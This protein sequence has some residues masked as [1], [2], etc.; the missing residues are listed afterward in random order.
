MRKI[1][2]KFV[3]F[4]DNINDKDSIFFKLI[5][6]RYDIEI[7]DSPEY[8]VYSVFGYEHLKYDC[9]RIFYT[10]EQVS[11]DFDIADY[12]I[13]F[14]TLFFNDRYL[15]FPL[16]A[17]KYSP[18]M[19]ALIETDYENINF[20][21]FNKRDFA[22]FTYSNSKATSPRDQFFDKLNSLRKVSSPGRHLNNT[23]FY[24]DNKSEFESGFKFSIAFENSSYE[25]YS[26]EKILDSFN[27]KTIP[28]YYGDETIETHFHPESFINLHNF[29]NFDEAIGYILKIEKDHESLQKM[30]KHKKFKD[31]VYLYQGQLLDFFDNIFSQDIVK[32]RRRPYSNRSR[33]KLKRLQ[34]IRL[35]TS[36]K[37]SKIF[38]FILRKAKK[39]IYLK[40]QIIQKI[41]RN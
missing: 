36:Y 2:I 24:V 19:L 40:K 13:G 9:I 15:R 27:A 1:K 41:R 39:I 4:W 33:E 14:D 11:P 8:I 20:E 25:G 10:G 28:I 37:R 31:N 16:Y 29:I 34:F 18:E 17:L 26:T 22:V 12:A 21:D 3:D 32:A 23:G 38:I 30:L 5:S 7:S 35:I 6:M